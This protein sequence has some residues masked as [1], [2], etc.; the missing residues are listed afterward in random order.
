M[1]K[2]NMY[3][4]S[5][6]LAFLIKGFKFD[7]EV[8]RMLN[9]EVMRCCCVEPTKQRTFLLAG[10]PQINSS[11]DFQTELS[12]ITI[13]RIFDVTST[14]NPASHD[15]TEIKKIDSLGFNLDYSILVHLH[16]IRYN[17]SPSLADV[18]LFL[19]TDLVIGKSLTYA[20]VGF[21]NNKPVI[22]VLTFKECVT[23]PFSFKNLLK[24]APPFDL[25]EVNV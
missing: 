3:N 17:A 1:S 14:Q 13:T 5:L 25:K 15:I 8:S 11:K 6:A 20:V 10:K 9:D 24:N 19:L 23:C 4:S 21:K 7:D 16:P 18:S 22:N 2:N 12:R